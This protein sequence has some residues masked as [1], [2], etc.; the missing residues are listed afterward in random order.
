MYIYTYIDPTILG[1]KSVNK[2]LDQFQQALSEK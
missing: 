2:A 1:R